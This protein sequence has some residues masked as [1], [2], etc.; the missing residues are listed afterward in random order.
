MEALRELNRNYVRSAAQV[1]VRWYADNLA[2]DYMATN[3]DG[4]VRRQGRLPRA[5]CDVSREK[6][7]SRRS[8]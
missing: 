4:F 2:R 8:T 1:D 6:A 7:I 3:P 5:Y